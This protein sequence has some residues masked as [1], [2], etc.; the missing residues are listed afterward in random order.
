MRVFV[1]VATLELVLAF[2]IVLTRAIVLT[3]MFAVAITVAIVFTP[4]IVVMIVV[5]LL[6]ALC[7][8]IFFFHYKRKLPPAFYNIG[9]WQWKFVQANE[10]PLDDEI[11]IK[12]EPPDY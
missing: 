5:F 3:I 2:T 8:A 6:I 10:E 1:R 11:L 7:C 9:R 4:V 12:Q